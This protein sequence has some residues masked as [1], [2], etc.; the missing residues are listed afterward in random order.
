MFAAHMQKGITH[1]YLEADIWIEGRISP[2][3]K[4][5][6][7]E[8]SRHQQDHEVLMSSWNSETTLLSFFQKSQNGV[9]YLLPSLF[10]LLPIL[11]IF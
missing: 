10:H 9:H 8:Y 11:K 4:I 5:E 6:E 1:F 2:G 7:A 3:I